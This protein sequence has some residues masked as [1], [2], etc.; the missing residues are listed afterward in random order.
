MNPALRLAPGKEH[1]SGTGQS[2]LSRFENKFLAIREGLIWNMLQEKS[3][4]FT[5]ELQM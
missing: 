4:V 2:A 5:L 1:E 3:S